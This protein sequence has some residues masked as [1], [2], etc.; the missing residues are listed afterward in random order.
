MPAVPT[1]H[2][3]VRQIGHMRPL[4]PEERSMLRMP[5]QEKLR[6]QLQRRVLRHY[7]AKSR[8]LGQCLHSRLR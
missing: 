4:P 3:I 2:T 7:F 6:G 5:Q 1:R 8:Y